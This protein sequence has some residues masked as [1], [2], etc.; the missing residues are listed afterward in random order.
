MG[1]G[2]QG[3]QAYQKEWEHQ[4]L[5]VCQMK[6]G[7][8]FITISI[9]VLED[10]SMDFHFGLDNLRLHQVRVSCEVEVVKLR[11]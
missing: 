4:R 2:V 10:N 6:M 1:M 9:N 8:M 5:Y 7:G 11:L 3:M